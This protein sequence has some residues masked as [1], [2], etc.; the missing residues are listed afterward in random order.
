[1]VSKQNCKNGRCTSPSFG[2]CP[3]ILL[4]QIMEKTQS[5][6]SEKIM[7]DDRSSCVYA[8]WALCSFCCDAWIFAMAAEIIH[9]QRI[10][11]LF[12]TCPR[13]TFLQCVNIF[14]PKKFRISRR[15]VLITAVATNFLCAE[16]RVRR[17]SSRT[18]QRRLIWA[19]KCRIVHHFHSSFTSIQCPDVFDVSEIRCKY[20]K[21][22][23]NNWTERN[24]M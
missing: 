14:L 17:I 15:I 3:Q 10:Y 12:Y 20:F 11:I 5:K 19:Q 24:W 9:S 7:T 13:C 22:Y 6:W 21:I 2:F 8:R 1:M 23:T 4:L 18:A 16:S